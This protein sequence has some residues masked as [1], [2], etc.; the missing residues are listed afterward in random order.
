[1]QAI[2]SSGVFGW[3][4]QLDVSDMHVHIGEPFW[5]LCESFCGVSFPLDGEYRYV[6]KNEI[7]IKSSA[8]AC[9]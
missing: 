7:C 3:I 9:K 2:H 8:C 1:M 4:E 6:S 5:S